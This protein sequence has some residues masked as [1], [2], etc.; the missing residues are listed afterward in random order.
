MDNRVKLIIAAV[1]G[2]TVAGVGA[3]VGLAAGGDDQALTGTAH[4]RATAAALEHAG[5]GTVI[6]TEAGD[7]GAAY[8]VEIRLADGRQIEVQLNEGFEVI[9]SAA[10]DD[11]GEVEEN[12]D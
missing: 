7:G 8:E 2:V 11:G 1:A 6:E 4:D 3:G 9:G 5:E 10:D 12:D